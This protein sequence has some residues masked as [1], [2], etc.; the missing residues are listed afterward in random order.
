MDQVVQSS[1]TQMLTFDLLT[2]FFNFRLKRLDIFLCLDGLVELWKG[3]DELF[4]AFLEQ[5]SG[6]SDSDSFL[7]LHHPDSSCCSS[8]LLSIVID[9]MLFF[10][11][12]HGLVPLIV[13]IAEHRLEIGFELVDDGDI[14]LVVLEE[15][16]IGR[17]TDFQTLVGYVHHLFSH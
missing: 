4:H 17:P 15:T 11:S 14:N 8:V 5:P 2:C 16:F 7:A 10:S 6:V 9:E 3:L 1:T 12:L 13:S